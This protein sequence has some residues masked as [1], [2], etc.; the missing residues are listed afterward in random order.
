MVVVVVGGGGIINVISF[1]V[2]LSIPF[3]SFR[4]N[5]IRALGSLPWN[6]SRPRT[7]GTK[8]CCYTMTKSITMMMMMMVIGTK[9]KQSACGDVTDEGGMF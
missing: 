1:R 9:Y 8:S 3:S 4:F 6:L 5:S 2:A 7:S